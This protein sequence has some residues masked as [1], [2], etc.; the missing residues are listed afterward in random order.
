[1]PVNAKSLESSCDN[2]ESPS[3]SSWEASS[4][5]LFESCLMPDEASVDSTVVDEAGAASVIGVL[6]ED[7]NP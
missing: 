3:C 7:E 5:H 6:I 1:M 2:S 4:E